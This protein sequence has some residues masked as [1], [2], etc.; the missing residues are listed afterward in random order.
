MHTSSTSTLQ[1][2]NGTPHRATRTERAIALLER[3]AQSE[4]ARNDPA[5]A[6]ALHK[7]LALL[8]E[9]RGELDHALR[10]GRS[11]A[12]L[13]PRVASAERAALARS[14]SR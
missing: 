13:Q 5:T 14:L 3:E 7:V 2:H 10:H 4:A 8:Y 12:T 6:L 1:P 9:Q 11:V